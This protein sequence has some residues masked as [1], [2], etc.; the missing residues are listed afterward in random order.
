MGV[1]TCGPQATNASSP[2]CAFLPSPSGRSA[3]DA[4]GRDVRQSSAPPPTSP[5]PSG[6]SAAGDRGRNA[7]HQAHQRLLP[8]LRSKRGTRDVRHQSRTPA[9]GS[10]HPTPKPTPSS[11]KK[12]NQPKPHPNPSP[13]P[14]HPRFNHV[15][16]LPQRRETG[17]AVLHRKLTQ[18]SQSA[19]RCPASG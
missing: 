4:A 17:V 11:T 7:R 6:G 15:N 18:N 2:F 5:S 9:G 14:A 8:F 13:N 1:D 12:P 3:A 19:R 10:Y 16:H